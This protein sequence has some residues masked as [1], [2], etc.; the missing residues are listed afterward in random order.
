MSQPVIQRGIPIPMRI[1]CHRPVR[2]PFLQMAIGDSFFVPVEDP[3]DGRETRRTIA[4]SA[5]RRT[6]EKGWKFSLRIVEGG[7]RCW[8]VADDSVTAEPELAADK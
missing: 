8:R 7:V 1:C 5:R 3:A 4:K 6:R 2:Y